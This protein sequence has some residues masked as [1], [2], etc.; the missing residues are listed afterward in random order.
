MEI[1]LKSKL[2]AKEASQQDAWN[3]I[4]E[5]HKERQQGRNHQHKLPE[6]RTVPEAGRR[7]FTYFDMVGCF[8]YSSHRFNKGRQYASLAILNG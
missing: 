5:K 7:A 3:R 8:Q 2:R 1:V 4:D 6:P